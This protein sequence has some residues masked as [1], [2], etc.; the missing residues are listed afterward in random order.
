MT[1]EAHLGARSAHKQ[2]ARPIGG[3]TP[4]LGGRAAAIGGRREARR[5]TAKGAA[6]KREAAKGGQRSGREEGTRVVASRVVAARVASPT[7]P[8]RS[9]SRGAPDLGE[10]VAVD[11]NF[12]LTRR[13][14]C[15]RGINGSGTAGGEA[16]GRARFSRVHARGNR[17]EAS[18]YRTLQCVFPAIFR[19]FYC[20]AT[21][22]HFVGVILP[23]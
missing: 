2:C 17:V 7:A 21:A 1:L 16:A 13:P 3:A 15:R 14:C 6:A 23:C 8:R 5:G 18:I 4:L 12:S 22:P 19:F 11:A 20:G 9:R 10:E